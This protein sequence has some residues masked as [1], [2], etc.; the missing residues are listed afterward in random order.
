[1]KKE[2][3]VMQLLEPSHYPHLFNMLHANISEIDIK[4][5]VVGGAVLPAFAPGHLSEKI[6]EFAAQGVD[7]AFCINSMH[8]LGLDDKEP[9]KGTSVATDG[10]LRA[11]S[12]DRKAGYT[13]FVVA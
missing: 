5:V 11:I 10:G 6:E 8:L 3:W 2:K 1:M 9:P 7:F 13:Y 12:A 4:V